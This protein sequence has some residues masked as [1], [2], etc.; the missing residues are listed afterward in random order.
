VIRG[1]GGVLAV[2]S[3][4]WTG[5]APATAAEDVAKAFGES[6]LVLDGGMRDS[7]AASTVVDITYDPPRVLREGPITAAELGLESPQRSGR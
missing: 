2:T 5:E 4:N 6:M 7:L 3:A 1:A